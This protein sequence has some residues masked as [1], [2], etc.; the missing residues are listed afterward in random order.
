MQSG[1]FH[2]T[3]FCGQE[4]D[5]FISWIRRIAHRTVY[6]SDRSD[7]FADR[8]N[9]KAGEGELL[10]IGVVTKASPKTGT[11]GSIFGE[12]TLPKEGATGLLNND[13]YD[14]L[15]SVVSGPGTATLG[16]TSAMAEHGNQAKRRKSNPALRSEP[17]R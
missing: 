15:N 3:I 6:Q 8:F 9:F 5:N 10:V 16:D 11:M 7:S 12:Q 14:E 13:Q 17:V 1:K 4:F 2:C